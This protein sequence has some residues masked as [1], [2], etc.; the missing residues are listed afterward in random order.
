MRSPVAFL[1]F[2]AS[3]IDVVFWSLHHQISFAQPLNMAAPKKRDY[4]FLFKLVVIGDS[5]LNSLLP[6]HQSLVDH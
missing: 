5:G 3:C 6:L 2:L 4:D 1:A